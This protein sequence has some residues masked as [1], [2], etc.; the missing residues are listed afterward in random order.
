M[1]IADFVFVQMREVFHFDVL[2]GLEDGL[3]VFHLTV[4]FVETA[5]GTQETYF[6]TFAEAKK[7][8]IRLL[9]WRPETDSDGLSWE[10]YFDSTFTAEEK[11]TREQKTFNGWSANVRFVGG[12]TLPDDDL[13]IAFILDVEDTPRRDVHY[14]MSQAS[15][16]FTLRGLLRSFC[17]HGYR[18]QITDDFAEVRTEE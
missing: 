4:D 11:G 10:L 3:A 12:A 13:F 7:L 9:Q 5:P 15:A 14:V 16:D 17:Q 8:A 18:L 6:L 1:K 2:G